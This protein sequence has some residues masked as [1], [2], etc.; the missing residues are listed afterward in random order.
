[1]WTRASQ[2]N[3]IETMTKK[4]IEPTNL[5]TPVQSDGYTVVHFMEVNSIGISFHSDGSICIHVDGIPKSTIIHFYGVF[6][7]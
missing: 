2:S 6:G 3:G 1:M 5:A 7:C 4:C